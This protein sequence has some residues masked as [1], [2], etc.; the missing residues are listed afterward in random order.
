M[1]KRAGAVTVE[2]CALFPR[3]PSLRACLHILALD[4]VFHR[5]EGRAE[6]YD[7]PRCRKATE[8]TLS[9]EPSS[10]ATGLARA[11]G[12]KDPAATKWLQEDAGSR[13]F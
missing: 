5:G 1:S 7:V 13:T 10:R 2:R 12:A 3:D 8:L 9:S 11:D 4:D 6:Y